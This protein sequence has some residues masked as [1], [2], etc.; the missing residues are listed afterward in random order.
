MIFFLTQVTICKL[1]HAPVQKNRSGLSLYPL[2]VEAA[3]QPTFCEALLSPQ[4]GPIVAA[5]YPP[6]ARRTRA[7][8]E[9]AMLIY[10]TLRWASRGAG[11]GQL[12]HPSAVQEG[13]SGSVG[14]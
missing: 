1:N 4:N 5:L 12:G 8:L 2:A 11:G 7:K 6:Y 3:K 13:K 14:H 9:F 10:A